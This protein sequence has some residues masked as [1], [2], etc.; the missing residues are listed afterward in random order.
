M[1]ARA[2]MCSCVHACVH[3]WIMNGNWWTVT[4]R[5]VS[6]KLNVVF[7]AVQISMT[8]SLRPT[9]TLTQRNACW[10]W[11]ACCTRCQ[12]TTMRRSNTLPNTSALSL[13]TD[14]PTRSACFEMQVCRCSGLGSQSFLKALKREHRGVCCCLLLFVGLLGSGGGQWHVLR[15]G[16][17]YGI[18]LGK[19]IWVRKKGR[20]LTCLSIKFPI[21]VLVPFSDPSFDHNLFGDTNSPHTLCIPLGHRQPLDP[22][23]ESGKPRVVQ[24]PGWTPQH[25]DYSRT[26]QQTHYINNITK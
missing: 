9:G 3:V 22:Y 5:R 4:L 23:L 25:C 14:K 16:M 19:K 17:K 26:V 1:C 7:M 21:K 6:C 15:L 11:S 24:T 13:L 10:S 12:S 20:I 18:F 2:C 8:R